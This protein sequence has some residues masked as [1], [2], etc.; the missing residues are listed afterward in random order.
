VGPSAGTGA[1]TGTRAATGT[2][3]ARGECAPG[4]WRRA[5]QLRGQERL[6]GQAL[7]GASMPFT[8]AFSWCECAPG[9]CGGMGP[10]GG[11]R[12]GTLLVTAYPVP[13]A[14]TVDHL[15]LTLNAAVITIAGSV[16]ARGPFDCT[17]N[18]R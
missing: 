6:R 10:V 14:L 4:G 15:L 13:A 17:L 12:G 18:K 16:C 8:A 11:A 5:A 9:W 7:R 1:A 3:I 2:G